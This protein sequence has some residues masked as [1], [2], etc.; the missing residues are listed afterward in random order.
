M[1]RLAY[2]DSLFPALPRHSLRGARYL[3]LLAAITAVSVPLLALMYRWLDDDAAAIAILFA[4]AAMVTATL[5]LRT[6]VSLALA[7][8]GFIGSLFVLKVWM[9]FHYG[10]LNAATTGWFVLCPLVAALT[11]S[12][13]A[14]VVWSALV[15][16]AYVVLFLWSRFVGP[17]IPYPV[18]APDVLAFAGQLGL[19]V[20][21][22]VIALC[23]R[24]EQD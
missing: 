7:R 12:T 15:F 4:G 22:T 20:L 2:F 23:F 9:A 13:R 3:A 1:T 10:G 5:L 19:L 21:V 24:A 14:A 8:N 18:R 6:G 16:K 11:G 17:F